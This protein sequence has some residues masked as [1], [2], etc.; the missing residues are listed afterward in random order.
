[1][2]DPSHPASKSCAV[3]HH[4]LNLIENHKRKEILGTVV[5]SFPFK[6]EVNA[7]AEVFR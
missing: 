7:E 1:M 5:P 2:A 4:W 6:A 3:A